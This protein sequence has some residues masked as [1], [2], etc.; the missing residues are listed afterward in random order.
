MAPRRAQFFEAHFLV[1]VTHQTVGDG[2]LTAY[3]IEEQQQASKH[4]Q[5]LL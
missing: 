3:I 5:M 1:N 4:L 2:Q